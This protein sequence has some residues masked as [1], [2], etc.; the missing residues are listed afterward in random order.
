MVL[1][2]VPILLATVIALMLTPIAGFTLMFITV[3]ILISLIITIFVAEIIVIVLDLVW[4]MFIVIFVIENRD[5]ISLFST[6]ILFV[7][8]Y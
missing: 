4:L 1:H 2:L 5:F 3:I 8:C 6:I 7:T